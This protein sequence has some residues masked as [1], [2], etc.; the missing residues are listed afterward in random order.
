MGELASQ[1]LV[2]VSLHSSKISFANAHSACSAS[3]GKL[4]GLDKELSKSLDIE[5]QSETCEAE[6]SSS[7]VGPLGEASRCVELSHKKALHHCAA[8]LCETHDRNTACASDEAADSRRSCACSRK[9]LVFLILTLNQCYPD[10]D[11]SLLR[12]R[13]FRKEDATHDVEPL[14]DSHLLQVS[15]ERPAALSMLASL[16]RGRTRWW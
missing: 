3:A 13:H 2:Q 5:V 15:K 8:A 7:P 10:Y 16:Q 12:A 6:L 9:T 11:F 1:P 4:T 14:V